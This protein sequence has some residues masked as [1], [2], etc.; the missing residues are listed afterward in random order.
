MLLFSL[1]RLSFRVLTERPESSVYLSKVL[2]MIL[3]GSEMYAFAVSK[4]HAF[5]VLGSKVT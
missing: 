3:F 1:N 4:E 2:C 5:S